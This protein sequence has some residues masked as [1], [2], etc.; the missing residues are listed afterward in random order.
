MPAVGL[1]A[2]RGV[3]GEGDVGV[4]LDGDLVVVP[5]HDEVAQLL[6]A[7]QRAGLA[8]HAL[9]HVAVGGDH[10]DVV[11]ERAGAG[12]GVGVEQAA[13]EAGRHGHA[14]RGGQA[15]AQRAGGDLDASGVP[16]LRMPRG[17]GAPGPQCLDVGEFQAEPAEV[18]LQVEGEA[19]VPAGQHE[20]VPA[21]PLGVAGIVAHRPLEE[22]VGQRRQTHG[23]AG[24]SVADLLHGVGGQHPHRVD[25]GRV[26]L[27]PIVGV[28]R[29][30]QRG[31]LFERRH[32]LTP[33]F[34]A[35]AGKAVVTLVAGCPVRAGFS[36]A[37]RACQQVT[38]R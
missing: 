9:L 8:G 19:A 15:L 7:R 23:R 2:G 18:E 11:I 1:I 20:P 35:S 5:E 24:M 31:N 10:I 14:H 32:E 3:L 34:V 27:G 29:S 25:G 4:V 16:E 38:G 37:H 13:F 6:G 36:A 21:Q 28:V 17:L 33:G 22:G 26:E 12:G 30:G